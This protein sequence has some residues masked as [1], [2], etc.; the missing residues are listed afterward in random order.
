MWPAFRGTVFFLFRALNGSSHYISFR[1]FSVPYNGLF[2]LL[3]R[4]FSCLFRGSTIRT[5]RFG[6]N[7]KILELAADISRWDLVLGIQNLDGAIRTVYRREEGQLNQGNSEANFFLIAVQM[8]SEAACFKFMEE[9]IIRND[10]TPNIKK[11]MD[12]FQNDWTTISSSINK[13]E[14]ETPKCTRSSPTFV[15]ST[16][17][18]AG[19]EHGG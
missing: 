5:T 3:I 6:G 16:I 1:T 7:Y 8:V 14:A 17:G 13:A 2:F 19:G 4:F 15:I 12:A 9:A 18:Q 11:K 10:N